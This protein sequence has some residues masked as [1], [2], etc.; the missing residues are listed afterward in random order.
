MN[1]FVK[2][3]GAA[4]VVVGVLI[5]IV[6]VGPSNLLL[7][8]GY[9]WMAWVRGALFIAGTTAVFAGVGCVSYGY[10]YF[11]LTMKVR[12]PFRIF[13]ENFFPRW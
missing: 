5:Y 3:A 4:L 12:L 6:A 10:N 11:P 8:P 9:T 7:S 1:L 13:P 2:L